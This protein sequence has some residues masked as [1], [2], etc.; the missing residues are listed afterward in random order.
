MK[1]LRAL[2][3]QQPYASLIASGKKTAEL[4]S[5]R[6]TSDERIAIHAGATIDYDACKRLGINPN[7][8]PTSV[9]LCEVEVTRCIDITKQN[10]RQ[11][12]KASCCSLR[13]IRLHNFTKAHLLHNV[14]RTEG[15]R[16]RGNLGLWPVRQQ[17]NNKAAGL[18][19]ELRS[20]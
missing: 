13:S 4:R 5:R 6:L 14:H 15:L 17:T 1:Q 7:S 12:A 3:V 10:Q 18:L 20:L 11:I 8:L 19:S 9:L 2:T 16:A